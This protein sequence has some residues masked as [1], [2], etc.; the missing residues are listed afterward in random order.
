MGSTFK[1]LISFTI[2]LCSRIVLVCG[3]GSGCDAGQF[4]VIG[5]NLVPCNGGST[6]NT[7]TA[8][9]QC[10]L[11]F[12]RRSFFCCAVMVE[13]SPPR[14]IVTGDNLCPNNR[15]VYKNGYT[16]QP[17]SCI[18]NSQFGTCPNGYDCVY[19][20]SS[21]G[22]YCCANLGYKFCPSGATPFLDPVTTRPRTCT[23][24]QASSC[25][26]YYTCQVSTVGGGNYCCPFMEDP[27]CGTGVDDRGFCTPNQLGQCPGGYECTYSLRKSK[28]VCCPTSI[29]TFLSAGGK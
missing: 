23:L 13:V 10:Q 3:Q 12:S 18:P 17:I 4:Q 5:N 14:Y 20:T 7:C 26:A 24:N 11:F 2:C 15:A 9:F 16:G 27:M 21:Q 25:P 1:A 28:F 29:A 22:H 6:V 19:S 8:P